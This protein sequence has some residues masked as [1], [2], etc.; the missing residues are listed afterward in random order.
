MQKK[1]IISF[2]GVALGLFIVALV[3]FGSIGKNKTRQSVNSHTD[4]RLIKRPCNVLGETA[5]KVSCFFYRTHQVGGFHLP[6]ALIKN[7]SK[8]SKQDKNLLILLSG[9]P[10]QGYST[11]PDELQ[12]WVAK[13]EKNNIESDFL[14]YDMRGTGDG[15]GRV[16]CKQYKKA[17]LELLQE[18]I[19]PE[20]EVAKLNETLSA[21]IPKINEQ[22]SLIRL[23]EPT[24]DTGLFSTHENVNDLAGIIAAFDYNN[25]HLWGVSY[26][27]RLALAA[28]HLMQVRTLIL[29]S[30]YPLNKGSDSDMYQN[31]VNSMQM[32]KSLYQQ[33][34]GNN[35]YAALFSKA[36]VKLE[37]DVSTLRVQTWN[38]GINVN[39]QFTP[40]RLFDLSLHVLYSPYLYSLYY[41]GLDAFVADGTINESFKMVIEH[42]VSSILDP[43]FN[44]M[45]YFATE[46]I[47]NPGE[48]A[49][50]LDD[51]IQQNP[52]FSSYISAHKGQNPCRVFTS[53]E[54]RMVNKLTMAH[55]PALAFSGEFDP[56]TP[57]S[58][59]KELVEQLP[60]LRLQRVDG[61]GHAP[62]M[63][64][65]CDWSFINNFIAKQSTD[66]SV[67]CNV[68]E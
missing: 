39:L 17:V 11:S 23:T 16:E 5:R 30:P 6:L 67:N 21:C 26:G 14:V 59:A 10:G 32:H 52:L 33:T 41:S 18:N 12:A 22:L 64:G 61:A 27:S 34:T 13:L 50:A 8:Q 51:L 24:F 2:I 44:T 31:V 60:T 37:S 68:P 9:G 57:W 1:R 20:D 7:E 62:L 29:D 3:F 66:I 63:A 58:W 15:R 19:P 40:H 28:S 43:T 48:D 56:V 55:K 25:V 54:E 4:S 46:C 35:N 49:N 53:N 45:V 38:E 65:D 47:D 36:L 42:F